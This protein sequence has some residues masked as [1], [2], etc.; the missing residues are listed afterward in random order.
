MPTTASFI[1]PAPASSPKQSREELIQWIPRQLG[2]PVIQVEGHMQHLEDAVDQA[3]R[4]FVAKKGITKKAALMVP[5][6][7]TQ[8]T[9]ADEMSRVVDVVFQEPNLDVAAIGYPFMIMGGLIP[10]NTVLS[11]QTVGGFYSNVYQLLQYTKMA[12]MIMGSDLEW[13]QNGRTLAIY[14]VKSPTLA[15]VEY[16]P[17]H[18]TIEQLEARDFL[19]VQNYALSWFKKVLGRILR[20]HK[21]LPGADGSIEMDGAELMTEAQEELDKL[22]EEIGKSGYPMM[23]VRG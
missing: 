19:L 5:G 9:L 3:V 2:Y 7:E 8:F 13:S 22:E 17:Y 14:G 18:V 6:T 16:I 20:K 21:S 12:K 11:H 4:W 15:V 10:S 23:I 1:V